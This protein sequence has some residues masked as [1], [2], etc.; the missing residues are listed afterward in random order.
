MTRAQAL[1]AAAVMSA[2][3]LA[4]ASAALP[5]CSPESERLNPAPTGS[6]P[7][8]DAGPIDDG[9]GTGGSG[10]GG[11][12]D[13]GPPKRT[14]IQRNPF[15][16]VAERENLLWDGDFEWYSPFSDQYGWLAGASTATL[17]FAF[18]DVRLGAACHS[19]IR[20]AA[21][22]KKRVIAG[23]AV[24]SQGNK[25]AV[26]FWAHVTAGACSKVVA[27]LVD[28][29]EQ[30]DPDVSIKPVVADPDASGWCQY[31][32]VVDARLGK[33]VLLITNLSDG[34]ALVDD[35]VIKK[36]AAA[37]SLKAFHG[38]H[39]AELSADLADARAAFARLRGPHDPPPS[40]ARRAFEQWKQR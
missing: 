13:A 38:P 24:A 20:C 1:G 12:I 32:A 3:V 40:A 19:G 10:G 5:G 7:V 17:G 35:V 6:G 8:I 34:E 30:V 18:S 27:T 9:G 23:L 22:K 33:P 39:T 15:G 14:I 28:F 2:A 16:N 29:G 26:S 21:L 11:V 36:V 4:A 37:M 25:L 31:D